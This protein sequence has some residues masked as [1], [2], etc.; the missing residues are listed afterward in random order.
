MPDFQSNFDID[1]FRKETLSDPLVRNVWENKYRWT[2]PDG[3]VEESI[4]ESQRRVVDAVYA[5]DFDADAKNAAMFAV[6]NGYFLP[7]GRINAGAGTGRN[8]T[9]LN[10]YVNE[11]MQDSMQGIQ[12]TIAKAAFTLQQG[13]GIGT[14]FSTLRPFG[15]LVKR[16]GSVSSGPIV[17]MDQMS[18]MS[19]TVC[20][21]GERRGAMMIT[22]RCDH[23]DV[24]HEDQFEE[25]IDYNGDRKLKNPSFISVKLQRGRLTQANISVLVTDA[26]MAAVEND[27]EWDLG[28]FY[29]RADGRHVDVYDKPFPY[30]HV[31]IDN[32]F[33]EDN[34]I[35]IA[36]DTMMPWYVYTRVKA[37]RIWGDIMISTY[38]YAEPGVIFVDRINA[39]NNLRYCEY[40]SCTNPCGEQ[41]LPEHGCCCLG[42]VNVAFMV[43]NPFTSRAH[44]D[45]MLYGRVVKTAVRFLDNVLDV[46]GYPLAKQREES[47]RKRRIGLGLTGVADALIQFGIRY[48]SERAV[49]FMRDIS[50]DLQSWSYE[51]SVE[52]AKERGS[53]PSFDVDRFMG[54]PNVQ[55]L[56]VSLRDKIRVHGIRNGVLNTEAP[57]G[58]ISI[59]SGNTGQGIEPVFSFDRVERKVR[60][61]DGSL[62]TMESTNYSYRLYEAMFGRTERKELPEQ[63]VGAM[64]LTAEEHVRMQAACQEH[65]DASISK[66]VNCPESMTLD[67]FRDVY[68]LAYSLG[69]KGCTTYRP[70]PESGRGSVLSV[71]E[72]NPFD[73]S[74]KLNS[75]KP[76]PSKESGSAGIHV[77]PRDRVLT[78]RTYKLKWPQTGDN[79]Y[80]TVNRDLDGLPMEV[81]IVGGGDRY[82]EWVQA[83]GR[84]LTAVLRRGGDVRFLVG[85]LTAVHAA[86]GGAFV[87][88]QKSFRSSIVAALGGVLEEE[89]RALGMYDASIAAKESAST[90]VAPSTVEVP[91]REGNGPDACPAC[92]AT[93]LV[94][95]EG[96]LRCLRCEY[97]KC[98]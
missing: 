48:G 73:A 51:A 61:P 52:L 45:A 56:P 21:A 29:P 9:L 24:W 62:L 81:F 22:L 37:R 41:P 39:R 69:C 87:P 4:E 12:R 42:S 13:G 38:K 19:E 89:F 92:H 28:S 78:G 10:C 95:E 88:E 59:Y 53:F 26:F 34:R 97:T 71:A 30:D 58:T 79:W 66:T 32:D 15:A 7:A 60:Q 5:Q 49:E 8:V 98:G 90:G 46:A 64:D 80:V 74:A 11:T 91:V 94:R 57:N 63:F 6:A 14:D 20:S 77:A 96:C 76:V 54:S 68:A 55:G 67:A 3:S 35:S 84:L 43:R 50:S 18:A 82:T 25:R 27:S 72:K 83:M 16:T 65:V 40:I 1:A 85:E 75:M 2:R 36:T 31:E 86:A 70:D 33:V 47:M 17:F 44:V 23:P 93:P